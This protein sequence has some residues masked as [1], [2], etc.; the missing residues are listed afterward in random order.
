MLATDFGAVLFPC[1]GCRALDDAGNDSDAAR[2]QRV[3]APIDIVRP[4]CCTSSA[5]LAAVRYGFVVYSVL[6]DEAT[7]DRLRKMLWCDLDALS[8][9]A[10]IAACSTI[11]E[12]APIRLRCR[13]L[14]SAILIVNST[15][16]RS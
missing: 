15:N 14:D 1:F 6:W 16:D 8:S 9:V 4:H 12:A 5:V 13:K 3:Q 2:A 11:R 7:I 10:S